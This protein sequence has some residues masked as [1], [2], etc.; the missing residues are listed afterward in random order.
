MDDGEQALRSCVEQIVGQHFH[1]GT[2]SI[3]SIERKRSEFASF[4]A[5]DIITVRLVSGEQFKIFLKDFGSFHHPKDTMKERRE[6]EVVVYRDILPD[7][8]LDTAKYYGSVRNE[9]TGRFWL[10]LEFVEGL[11]IS[12]LEFED[13]VPS[14]GWLGRM[15]GYFSKHPELWKN[16]DALTVHNADFFHS[17]AQQALQ[18]VTEFSAVLGHRLDPIVGRYDKTVAVMTSQPLTF[19]HGTYRP[20]Q[21]IIDKTHTPARICPVDF[22][23]AAI[24]ASLYDLTFLVDGFDPPRL[25]QLF[26]A[27]RQEAEGCGVSVADDE[28]MKRVVDCFRLHRVM[29]WLSLSLARGYAPQSIHKLMGMAEEL[30]SLVP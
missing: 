14:A 23:K 7:A 22:E 11:P 5:S 2:S 15:Y 19:V 20:A 12:H 13:W 8:R 24:G 6:R 25:K 30:R 17:T 26:D 3:E 16:C 18:S 28:E 27:Y 21:I 29:S 9:T 1:G 4:Y 10:L